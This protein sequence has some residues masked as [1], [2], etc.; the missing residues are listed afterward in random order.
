MG[1][2]P[3]QSDQELSTSHNKRHKKICSIDNTNVNKKIS[4]DMTRA[5]IEQ[6]KRKIEERKQNQI[7]QEVTKRR[8][9]Q[10]DRKHAY[11]SLPH[12]MVYFS[13]NKS[14]T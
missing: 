12:G 6:R 5:K 8:C 3:Y 4:K 1:K 11:L 2:R 9:L 13:L 10:H 14:S 7:I